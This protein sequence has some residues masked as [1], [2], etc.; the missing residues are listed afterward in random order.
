M[1]MLFTSCVAGSMGANYMFGIPATYGNAA[2]ITIY[3][4]TP[5]SA[6]AR[7]T[8]PYLN[9][10][11]HYIFTKHTY[12]AVSYTVVHSSAGGLFR[13]IE[14]HSDVPIWA[15][16]VLGSAD[17]FE[18]F[19]LQ[20]IDPIATEYIVASYQPIA[21]SHYYFSQF[22]LVGTESDTSVEVTV[23]GDNFSIELQKFET[24]LYQSLDDVSE[25]IIPSDKPISVISGASCGLVPVGVGTS[26]QYMIEQTPP[27][28]LYDFNFIVPSLYPL[29]SYYL[30]I[31]V[32]D[33]DTEISFIH[34]SSHFIR[35]KNRYEFFDETFDD[36]PVFI[37]ASKPIM[38]MIYSPN[39]FMMPAQAMAQ[40]QSEY[41]FAVQSTYAPNT[42]VI[43]IREE[44]ISGL[45]VDGSKTIFDD[46]EKINITVS[47]H[48][49]TIL[50]IPV[51]QA[52]I[53][54][55]HHSNGR[56]FG[57]VIYGIA[58]TTAAYG[59]SLGAVF[60]DTGNHNFILCSLIWVPTANHMNYIKPDQ[61]IRF[62]IEPDHFQIATQSLS[63]QTRSITDLDTR[64]DG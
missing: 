9:I 41:N 1:N 12:I 13:G 37:Q 2:S 29:T 47:Y 25:S 7:L 42:L 45:Y 54:R 33:D 28:N 32:A 16:V 64:S 10:D 43:T 53:H 51:T 4:T 63:D 15:S 62:L 30:R 17:Y 27:T 22:L 6:D 26:C 50:F 44:D 20:P 21:T 24:Y 35:F 23:P 58:D 39:P 34:G 60:T 18:G 5:G 57:A 14:L 11:Q 59:M 48:T 49:Y 31:F 3:L 19:H 40:Y 55:V 36:Q 56:T 8:I 61:S 52:T 38:V 46:A